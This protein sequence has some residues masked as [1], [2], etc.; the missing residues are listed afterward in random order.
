MKYLNMFFSRFLFAAA[1]G[2]AL[3]FVF[4]PDGLAREKDPAS[5]MKL[6]PLPKAASIPS[7]SVKSGKVDDVRLKKIKDRLQN[8]H[9]AGHTAVSGARP[10]ARE[11]KADRVRRLRRALSAEMQIKLRP[12]S[13][14]PRQIKVG[15]IARREGK[16]LQQAVFGSGSR[17]ERDENTAG[18]FLKSRKGLLRIS[19]PEKEMRL[20]R[21]FEDFLGR[22]HVRYTQRYRGLPVWPA[23]LNVHLDASGDVDLVNG[24]YVPTPR[25]M[26]TVPVWSAEEALEKARIEIAGGDLA[27]APGPEL[28]IYAPG[29]RSPRLAWKT[30]LAISLEE[31]WLVVVDAANGKIL[32]AYNQVPGERVS[33]SG[34]DLFGDTRLLDV[35]SEKGRYYMVNTAK[36]MYNPASDPSVIDKI[37]GGIIILDLE[38]QALPDSGN[39]YAPR[40][41]SASPDAGW[42]PDAVSLAYNLSETYDYFRKRHGRDSINAEGGSILGFVRVDENYNN[43]FWTSEYNGVFFGDANPYAGVLDVVAHECTHGVTAYTCNLVYRDQPGALNEALSDIFG[44]MVE[45]WS[46]GATDWQNSTGLA[47]RR[48][49]SDPSSVS[50]LPGYPYPGKMSEFYSRSDPLLQRLKD[51]D[52]GGV[53]VNMTIVSHCFYLL[54]EGMPGAIGLEDA[55]KIFYRAQTVHL[56][57]GSQFVDARLA[58]IA[59]AEELFGCRFGSGGK[60]G[61]GL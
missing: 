2:C 32:T 1:L 3:M 53:H 43:A 50:I 31:N 21:Y 9:P 15:S 8:L 12:H 7:P 52:Y 30:E 26:V 24:A 41:S 61:A 37:D 58:C 33:G 59:S 57:S 56:V 42:V 25:R 14:T 27:E 29:D 13:R 51:Q 35:W 39:L 5:A 45:A 48:N 4:S 47:D 11:K 49:L 55:A 16:V 40:A 46:T 28:I 22:R 17:R 44:E 38:N 60:S 34:I 54:A 10:A 20:A 19:E 18:A 36:P 23:E 6:I